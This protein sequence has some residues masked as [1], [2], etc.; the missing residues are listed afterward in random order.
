MAV[1]RALSQAV[2]RAQVVAA[3]GGVYDFA[4]HASL[5]N[6][7]VAILAPREHESGAPLIV[8]S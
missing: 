5:H 4:R 1:A 3:F 7:M 2:G 8:T 6:T